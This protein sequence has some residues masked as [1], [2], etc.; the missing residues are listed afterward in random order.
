MRTKIN[1]YRSL[2][3][4]D[5][6]RQRCFLRGRCLA[7]QGASQSAPPKKNR[8]YAT[9][10]HLWDP[11][12]IHARGIISSRKWPAASCLRGMWPVPRRS[13]RKRRRLKFSPAPM[14][15]RKS[16]PKAN[17]MMVHPRLKSKIR[18][19][20]LLKPWAISNVPNFFEPHHFQNEITHA[21]AVA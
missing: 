8:T 12:L 17:P 6:C 14:P 1:G 10:G 7:R 3:D 15:S 19:V 13:Q 18:I 11:G 5:F 4:S 9:E 16:R 21:P 20:D 2:S